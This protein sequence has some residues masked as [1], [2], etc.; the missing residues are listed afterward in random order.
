MFIYVSDMI[1][2]MYLSSVIDH[3]LLSGHPIHLRLI[4]MGYILCN[5][6]VNHLCT[7]DACVYIANRQD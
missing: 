7:L 6:H 4:Y 2:S 5:I 1:R 3:C